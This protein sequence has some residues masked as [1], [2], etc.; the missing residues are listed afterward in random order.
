MPYNIDFVVLFYHADSAVDN[1]PMLWHCKDPLRAKTF[2][3]IKSYALNFDLRVAIRE[4]WLRRL[5]NLLLV[6][7]DSICAVFL[8]GAAQPVAS[9]DVAMLIQTERAFFGDLLIEELDALDSYQTLVI[10]EVLR[11][12][13]CYDHK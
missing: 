12:I 7:D 3:G 2:I 1:R 13:S 4:T 5:E 10:P 9:A 8:V 11:F 6:G